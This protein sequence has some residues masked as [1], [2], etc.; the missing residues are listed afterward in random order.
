MEQK[1]SKIEAKE[2]DIDQLIKEGEEKHL[3]LK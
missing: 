3:K 2:I 1:N